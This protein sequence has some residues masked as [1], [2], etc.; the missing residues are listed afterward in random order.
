MT[1]SASFK[2]SCLLWFHQKYKGEGFFEFFRKVGKRKAPAEK[3]ESRK[4]KKAK[5]D[6]NKPKRAPSA[7]FVFLLSISLD[8][9][10]VFVVV[11]VLT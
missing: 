8:V 11:S 4:E 1:G 7:F 6:P 3:G 5:K 9:K 2:A 10:L